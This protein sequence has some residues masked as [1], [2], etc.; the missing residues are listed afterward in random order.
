MRTPA[1]ER[2]LPFL[3]WDGDCLI[4]TGY[5]NPR[6][7]YAQMM[8]WVD[9]AKTTRRVHQVVYANTIGPVPPDMEV[10]HTCDNRICA[11]PE[12]LWLGTH[13]ENVLDAVAKGRAT[14]GRVHATR[15][16]H[17]HEFT[18]ENTRIRTDGAREC[19]TCRRAYEARR[20]G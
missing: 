14:G 12:H 16:V 13:H 4:W 10:C 19:R 20:R 9:N 7:G 2:V 11:N 8:E 18:P 1:I 17:D 3:Q 6:S 15:C 5:V